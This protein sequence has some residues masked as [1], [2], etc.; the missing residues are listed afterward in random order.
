MGGLDQVEFNSGEAVYRLKDALDV[1]GGVKDVGGDVGINKE[2]SDAFIQT[3]AEWREWNKQVLKAET[4][5]GK[6]TP[7]CWALL[8]ELKPKIDD[9]FMRCELVAYSPLAQDSLNLEDKPLTSETGLLEHKAL[10]E[11][12]LSK[13]AAHRPLDMTK[14]LNPAWRGK[15]ERFAVLAKPLLAQAGTLSGEDWAKVQDALA[16]FAKVIAAKP[17]PIKPECVETASTKTVDDFDENRIN[18]LLGTLS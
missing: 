1:I 10:A 18:Q 4:P 14:G 15:V 17:E 6:N 13:A 3:V 7:E 16:P 5:L 12:P 11:L 8:S 2:I 9:Y